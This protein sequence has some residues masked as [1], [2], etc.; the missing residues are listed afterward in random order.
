MLWPIT[1]AFLLPVTNSGV[2]SETCNCYKCEEKPVGR[3]AVEL[4]QHIRGAS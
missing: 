3:T 1:A 4:N 2:T